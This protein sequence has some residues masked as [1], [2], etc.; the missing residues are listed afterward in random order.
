MKVKKFQV[1]NVAIFCKSGG[2]MAVT[3]IVLFMGCAGYIFFSKVIAGQYRDTHY[4]LINKLNGFTIK[5]YT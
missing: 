4:I 2:L 1:S 5:K 3:S